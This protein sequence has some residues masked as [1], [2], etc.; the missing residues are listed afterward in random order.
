MYNNDTSYLFTAIAPEEVQNRMKKIREDLSIPEYVG[1]NEPGDIVTKNLAHVTIKGAFSLKEHVTENDILMRISDLTFPPLELVANRYHFFQSKDLGKILVLL[2][3]KNTNINHLHTTIH[4][5]LD[6]LIYNKDK[7]FKGEQNN[8]TPH[9]SLIYNIHPFQED[10]ALEKIKK[11]LP[12]TFTINS[13]LF[14]GNKIGVRH[15]RKILKE[16]Y[17]K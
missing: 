3:E 2:L 5:Q 17:A 13:I 7:E 8:Y 16:I 14:L 1:E 4:Q 12:F 11:L 6:P 9:L 10:Q 15:T